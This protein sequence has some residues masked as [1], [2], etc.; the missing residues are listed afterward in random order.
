M[1]LG[2]Q[3]TVLIYKIVM[4][5]LK[6]KKYVFRISVEDDHGTPIAC[7]TIQKLLNW[8]EK[9]KTIFLSLHYT[10]CTDRS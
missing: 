2:F 9:K 7:V 8:R 5:H 10:F 6:N 3:P 4:A 1:M